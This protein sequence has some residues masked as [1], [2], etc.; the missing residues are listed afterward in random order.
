MTN[1]CTSRAWR[2][3]RLETLMRDGYTCVWCGGVATQADHVI[4]HAMGGPD[5]LHNL[6]A[7]CD[8]CNYKRG[9]KTRRSLAHP[10]YRRRDVWL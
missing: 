5:A 1:R 9:R 3:L 2:K 8:S 4:A 6:V 7:S 10:S